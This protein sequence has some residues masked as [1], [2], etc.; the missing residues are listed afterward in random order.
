MADLEA[1]MTEL[2]TEIEAADPDARPGYEPV[3]ARLIEEMTEAEMTVPAEI[4]D[5]HDELVNENIEAQFD[6]MPV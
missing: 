1:R 2:K 3:L 6:N 5:L 4:R